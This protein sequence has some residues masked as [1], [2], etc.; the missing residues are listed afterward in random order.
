M[1]TEV[2]ISVNVNVQTCPHKK[3]KKRKKNHIE[4]KHAFTVNN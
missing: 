3:R 2:P 4:T 1:V